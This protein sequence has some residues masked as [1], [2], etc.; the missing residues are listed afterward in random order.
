MVIRCFRCDGKKWKDVSDREVGEK[1]LQGIYDALRSHRNMP[2][3]AIGNGL[4][5]TQVPA[6]F[7]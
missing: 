1:T 7:Y 4:T 6:S 3:V 5:K 2:E